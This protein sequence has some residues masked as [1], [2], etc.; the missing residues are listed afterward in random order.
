MQQASDHRVVQNHADQVGADDHAKEQQ[1][2]PHGPVEQ[3]LQCSPI[4]VAEIQSKV[5]VFSK[6]SLRHDRKMHRTNEQLS[7]DEVLDLVSLLFYKLS[8]DFPFL[9]E[10][11]IH[12]QVPLVEFLQAFLA[13]SQSLP[14]EML[15]HLALCS[16]DEICSD[17]CPYDVGYKA[18]NA[19]KFKIA[20]VQDVDV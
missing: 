20:T 5:E 15:L 13:L 11:L 7:Q 19:A 10:V 3:L 6:I 12:A 8:I 18:A 4:G 17:K 14:L 9:F 1:D 2:R 16:V